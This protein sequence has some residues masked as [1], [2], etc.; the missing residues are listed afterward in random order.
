[1][2]EPKASKEEVSGARQDAE[3]YLYLWKRRALYSIVAF[4]LSCAA[5]VPFSKGHSLH[6]YAEP[7]GRILVYLTMALLI[8]LVIC[9][10]VA[11]NSWFFVRNLKSGKL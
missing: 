9:V 2:D 10:G 11:I 6:A 8:P 4:F 5:V 3:E 7:F 1:M